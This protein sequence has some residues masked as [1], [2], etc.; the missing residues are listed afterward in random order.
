MDWP[1][2]AL[3]RRHPRRGV[4]PYGPV[5]PGSYWPRLWRDLDVRHRV[6]AAVTGRASESWVPV[7]PL[8]HGLTASHWPC[9]RCGTLLPASESSRARDGMCDGCIERYVMGWTNVGVY[10]RK[11]PDDAGSPTVQAQGGGIC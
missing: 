8:P 4:R 9:N 1:V 7:S 6:G 2:P 3:Q 11:W 5:A 10:V